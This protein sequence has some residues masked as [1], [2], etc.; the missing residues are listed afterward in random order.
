MG[1]FINPVTSL[2]PPE[3]VYDAL[4]RLGY[5][6]AEITTVSANWRVIKRGTKE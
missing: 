4:K 3:V 1:D 6:M 5:A 2:L